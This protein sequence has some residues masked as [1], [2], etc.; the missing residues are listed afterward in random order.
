M[1]AN[2]NT[3]YFAEL[4][5]MYSGITN[6]LGALGHIK[7]GDPL[8]SKCKNTTTIRLLSDFPTRVV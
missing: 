4:N 2:R 5:R 7:S 6:Q 1:T 8:T 3:L